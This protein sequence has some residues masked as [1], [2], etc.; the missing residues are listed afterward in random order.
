MSCYLIRMKQA[1]S[2][3]WQA[4]W[5]PLVSY[6]IISNQ[7]N[8]FSIEITLAGVK[9]L[10]WGLSSKIE[11]VHLLRL[12]CSATEPGLLWLLKK[13]GDCNSGSGSR[14]RDLFDNKTST[15]QRDQKQ[16]QNEH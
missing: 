9:I 16:K 3:R 6:R 10:S 14:T 11:M 1:V 13:A 8:V 4:I 7:P 2:L 15:R 12:T 5:S